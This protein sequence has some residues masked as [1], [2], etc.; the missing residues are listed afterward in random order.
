MRGHYRGFG[1]RTI[2]EMSS[3]VSSDD[4]DVTFCGGRVFHSRVAATRPEKLDRR[5]L[6]YYPHLRASRAFYE[7]RQKTRTATISQYVSVAQ[8]SCTMF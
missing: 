1:E 6:K 2:E 7:S 5:W 4:A 3:S 8:Y